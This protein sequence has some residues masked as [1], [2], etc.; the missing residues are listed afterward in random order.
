MV[1][2]SR[3][4]KI[5]YLTIAAVAAFILNVYVLEPL[6]DKRAEANKTCTE[7][8][9]QVEQA[10]ATLQR[11]KRIRP[12]WEQ[13]QQDGLGHDPQKAEAMVYRY[14][15]ETSEQSG[16]ELGSIQ[17]DRI[18]TESKLGE[19]DFILSGTGSMRAVTQF[20]WDLETAAIPLKI[21]AYQL[22]AKN[23][24][25][26]VMTIQLEL[27]TIYIKDEPAQKKES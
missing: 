25:A 11:Q 13:M 6:M 22:G 16:L 8:K 7:L 26:E 3:E 21:N 18:A 19:I 17:P 20:L 23:E 12:R 15:E 27:S 1:L 4:R 9:T 24:T 2:T 10:Q 14:L 5:L